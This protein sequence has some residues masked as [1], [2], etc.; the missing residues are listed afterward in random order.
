VVGATLG[1]LVFNFPPA[2]IFMGDGGSLVLG[3]V[4]A[5]CAVRLTYAE[6]PP[7]DESGWQWWAVFTPVVVMAI[8]LYD[9]VGVTLIRWSQGRSPLVGDTQHF[10]HRL[11]KRGLSRPAAVAVIYACTAATGVGGILL[12]HVPGWAAVMVVVQTALILL[13]LGL[14]EKAENNR[15]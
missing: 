10:S 15:H 2:S 13:V 8:P 3:F 4:L 5:F 1:F 12:G 14:L 9:L 11:V 6:L 7:G